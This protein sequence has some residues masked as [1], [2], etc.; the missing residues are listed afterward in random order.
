MFV[1]PNT[2]LGCRPNLLTLIMHPVLDHDGPTQV[3][4]TINNRYTHREFKLKFSAF[5]KDDGIKYTENSKK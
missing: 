3:R 1:T 5:L 2:S 4:L